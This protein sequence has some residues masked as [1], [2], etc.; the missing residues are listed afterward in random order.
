MRSPLL[1]IGVGLFA[2]SLLLTIVLTREASSGVGE[3]QRL[4]VMSWFSQATLFVGSGLVVVGAALRVLRPLAPKQG[5][6]VESV[7]YWGG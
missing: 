1:L 2:V 6:P 3:L 4:G 5:E 7:D